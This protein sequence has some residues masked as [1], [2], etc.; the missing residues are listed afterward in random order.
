VK[1]RLTAVPRPEGSL[2]A[3]DARAVLAEGARSPS[4]E[5]L[6][7]PGAEV[8]VVWLGQRVAVIRLPEEGRM[9]Q[10]WAVRIADLLVDPDAWRWAAGD[11]D[12]QMVA[13]TRRP[14]WARS[15]TSSRVVGRRA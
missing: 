7:P 6:P 4:P 11:L 9:P 12:A 3:R 10:R 2:P 1:V 13:E 15:P 8:V 14:G 5:P